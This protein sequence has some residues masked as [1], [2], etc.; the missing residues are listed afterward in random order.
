MEIVHKEHEE[1]RSFFHLWFFVFF[2]DGFS[3]DAK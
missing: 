3:E 2:V 1:A